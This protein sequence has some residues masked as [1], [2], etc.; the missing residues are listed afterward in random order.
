MKNRDEQKNP[1]TSRKGKR[2]VSRKAVRWVRDIYGGIDFG[3]S[4]KARVK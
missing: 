2:S 4:F 3:K 1:M